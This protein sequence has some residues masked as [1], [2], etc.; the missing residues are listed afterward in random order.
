MEAS[1]DEG[2]GAMRPHR[3]RALESA[4][5]VLRTDSR[6]QRKPAIPS[7]VHD[8][9]APA[10]QQ[11]FNAANYSFGASR[12]ANLATLTSTKLNSL[13]CPSASCSR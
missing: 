13:I 1:G 2:V 5:R 8:V 3:Q 7:A 11:L 4:A 10:A 6:N 9:E 12:P